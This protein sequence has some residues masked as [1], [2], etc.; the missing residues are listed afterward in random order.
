[1]YTAFSKEMTNLTSQP[2]TMALR[3]FLDQQNTFDLCSL[4]GSSNHRSG[5]A[6]A[7]GVGKSTLG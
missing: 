1:M 3:A 2:L 5:A 4:S 6:L 7:V